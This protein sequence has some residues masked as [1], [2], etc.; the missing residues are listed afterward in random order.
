MAPPQHILHS[1]TIFPVP[2]DK[3]YRMMHTSS[4]HLQ[5]HVL[6]HL[7]QTLENYFSHKVNKLV[8]IHSSKVLITDCK[9]VSYKLFSNLSPNAL[10]MKNKT[11]I[12][13]Q[14]ETFAFGTH[15][16][17]L[18]NS[19]YLCVVSPLCRGILWRLASLIFKTST[20]HAVKSAPTR[21]LVENIL[22]SHR[23]PIHHQS[24]HSVKD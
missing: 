19:N 24:R 14:S 8:D 5:M 20:L 23:I 17:Q 15:F 4:W 22:T 7:K 6:Y 3:I 10:G 2:L 1:T 9:M 11:K 13:C 16:V 18:Q 12:S 21:H